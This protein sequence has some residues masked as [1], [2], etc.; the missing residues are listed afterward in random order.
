MARY[1]P[2]HPELEP[3]S[4]TELLVAMAAT[5]VILLLVARVWLLFEAFRFP[6]VLTWQ[7]LATGA[8]L[9]IGISA[10]SAL[11]YKLWP[12]YQRSA[13]VYLKFV[14]APLVLSDCVWIGLL[15]GM[16]EELLFRG[17]MLPAIGLNTTGL[18]VSSLCFGILH[19]SGRG[20]WP[21]AIWASVV[22]LLLGG[23]ALTTN[24]LL[25][26]IVAHVVTNFVSSLFWQLSQRQS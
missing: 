15:P 19:M 3:L 24:N 9:G 14:L 6:L 5:A 26:P 12:T 23:C 2:E 13:D 22:G 25:V 7:A 11:V 17:V 8:A 16:S 4:R 1:S 21:Y 10:T 20:Q 18:V